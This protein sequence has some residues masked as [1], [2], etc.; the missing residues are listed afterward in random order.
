MGF[1]R[2][3]WSCLP[4]LESAITVHHTPSLFV[5][6]RSFHVFY[7]LLVGAP[8]ALRSAIALPELASCAYLS[9]VA[10]GEACS[11]IAMNA[12][13][14]LSFP[15][16]L[17]LSRCP[18]SVIDPRVDAWPSMASMTLQSLMFSTRFMHSLSCPHLPYLSPICYHC[19][20]TTLTHRLCIRWA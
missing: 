16:I 6:E 18:H 2:S 17:T 10:L 8:A 14:S 11:C 20:L 3:K 7:Q 13:A 4:C 1:E 5:G 12:L 15:V 9:Q 19:I